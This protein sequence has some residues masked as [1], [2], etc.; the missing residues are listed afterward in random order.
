MHCVACAVFSYLPKTFV[1]WGN[2]PTKKASFC[3]K[4]SLLSAIIFSPFFWL[5]SFFSSFYQRMFCNLSPQKPVKPV[6]PSL[7]EKEETNIG[8][9]RTM[10]FVLENKTT[11]RQNSRFMDKSN[12]FFEIS[13]A[14]VGEAI[15]RVKEGITPYAFIE[16]LTEEEKDFFDSLSVRKVILAFQTLD[17]DVNASF[18]S[19]P[20]DEKDPE[21]EK[22]IAILKRII[23]I[24]D[25]HQLFKMKFTSAKLNVPHWHTDSGF[26]VRGERRNLALDQEEC[27]EM[28]T[29][30]AIKGPTTQVFVPTRTE[31]EQLL[32]ASKAR[33]QLFDVIKKITD[34]NP[35]RV[36][37]GN[38]Y[39][40]LV[41]HRGTIH[42][43]FSVPSSEY[44][45][46]IVLTSFNEDNLTCPL[47]LQFDKC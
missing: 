15:Q 3:Q 42:R 26:Q 4:I 9:G 36:I 25:A 40:L 16:V 34:A 18:R 10:S 19:H 47:K 46:R 44:P 24:L 6:V 28:R 32:V 13:L 12:D 17:I 8:S 43:G 39:D 30:W 14:A 20:I 27:C 1:I 29:T 2:L 41:F 45:D 7:L 31:Y 35:S 11:E 38:S 5:N 21:T 37:A 33:E 22:A 23:R